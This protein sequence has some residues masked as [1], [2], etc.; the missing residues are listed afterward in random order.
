MAMLAGQL[1]PPGT[2]SKELSNKQHP[3]AV[4]MLIR[5]IQKLHPKW[6]LLYGSISVVA[7]KVT[8]VP[9]LI[10]SP[11]TNSQ[12]DESLNILCKAHSTQKTNDTKEAVQVPKMNVHQ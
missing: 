9:G 5:C 4:V 7:E 6:R 1:V 11:E 10:T 3:T 8:H 12:G 2:K